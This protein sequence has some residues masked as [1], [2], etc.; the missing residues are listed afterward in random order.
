V[1]DEVRH[2]AQPQVAGLQH[3]FTRELVVHLRVGDG[4][5]LHQV[6]L[7]EVDNYHTEGDPEDNSHQDAPLVRPQRVV[8]LLGQPHGLSQIPEKH[9]EIAEQT[10]VACTLQNQGQRVRA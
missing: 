1:E 5:R 9:T 7:L 3:E 6:E 4:A 2:P 8:L 10:G